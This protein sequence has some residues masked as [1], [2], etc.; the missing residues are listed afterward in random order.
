M[1]SGKFQWLIVFMTTFCL[2]V[3]AKPQYGGSQTVT[4][5]QSSSYT[6][7]GQQRTTHQETV[8]NSSPYG[9]T[10]QTTVTRQTSSYGGYG[11]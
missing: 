8:S 6:P 2:L 11:K 4:R 9:Q 7:T 3:N 10:Q 5:S 1:M